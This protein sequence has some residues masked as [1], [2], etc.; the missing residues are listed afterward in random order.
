MK[1]V[2]KNECYKCLLWQLRYC[3]LFNKT[4]FVDNSKENRFV[5]GFALSWIVVSVVC[6]RTLWQW[7]LWFLAAAGRP[8]TSCTSQIKHGKHKDI[9]QRIKGIFEK[10]LWSRQLSK[11]RCRTVLEHSLRVAIQ[12]STKPKSNRFYDSSSCRWNQGLCYAVKEKKKRKVHQTVHSEIPH[13][14]YCT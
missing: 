1:I 14:L 12:T 4:K 2:T 10:C 7:E 3:I 6:S 13:H 8:F 5:Q 9:S 11:L